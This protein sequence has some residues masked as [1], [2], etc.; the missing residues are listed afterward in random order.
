MTSV[1]DGEYHRWVLVFVIFFE[2][3]GILLK[4]YVCFQHLPQHGKK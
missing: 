4:L 1:G 2:N 3:S